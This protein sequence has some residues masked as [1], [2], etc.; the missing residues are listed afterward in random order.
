MPN[1]VPYTQS[2]LNKSRKDKFQIVLNFPPR[3][4]AVLTKSIP[5]NQ[6]VNG[7]A[8]Q[9]SVYGSIVPP[10]IIPEVAARYSGQTLTV[11]SHS[12]EQYEP[13]TFNF[14]VDNRF[15]NWWAIKYWLN[16]LNDEKLGKYDPDNNAGLTGILSMGGQSTTGPQGHWNMNTQYKADISV[17]AL[18][19]YDKRTMEFKYTQAF[20]T[21]LGG[22][23]Y[24]D[25]TIDE[26]ETTAT[27]SY[28]QFIASLV[29][30]VDSL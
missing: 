12:R 7:D 2:N 19:E 16:V 11:T 1:S 8:L 29:E 17:Y 15:Y 9:F 3:I 28:S 10:T 5:T 27:F 26:I 14:T 21:E 6:L 24:N 25:R 13:L 4:K 22:I 20:P 30:N 18:D 23:D